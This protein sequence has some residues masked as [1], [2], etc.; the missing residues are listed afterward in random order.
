MNNT[1][2][3]DKGM[4]EISNEIGRKM[5]EN[6]INL[7]EYFLL[8]YTSSFLHFMMLFRVYIYYNV[9]I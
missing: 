7:I 5:V 8:F 6:F 3:V 4:F 1:E 9:F 2:S